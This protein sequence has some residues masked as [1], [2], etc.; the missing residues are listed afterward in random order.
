V[1]LNQLVDHVRI[2]LVR[3]YTSVG[4]S[5]DLMASLSSFSIWRTDYRSDE[6]LIDYISE[7]SDSV[8]IATIQQGLVKAKKQLGIPDQSSKSKKKK[9][10]EAN[11]SSAGYSMSVA[12]QLVVSIEKYLQDDRSGS[13]GT[14]YAMV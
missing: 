4:I 12:E 13:A 1:E 9:D 3:M 6:E 5:I 11:R 8:D 2:L 10:T 7:Y 14:G